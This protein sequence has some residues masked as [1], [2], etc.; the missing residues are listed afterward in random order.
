MKTHWDLRTH[1]I[2][3]PPKPNKDVVWLSPFRYP[4]VSRD[5]KH[6]IIPAMSLWDPNVLAVVDTLKGLKN[7]ERAYWH[8]RSAEKTLLHI[9]LDEHSNVLDDDARV[10]SWKKN[11]EHTMLELLVRFTN[12]TMSSVTG[13]HLATRRQEREHEYNVKQPVGLPPQ[14]EMTTASD[15]IW[16]DVSWEHLG[17]LGVC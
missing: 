3:S 16:P 13:D 2:M 10:E 14:H 8:I 12:D 5:G 7:Y 9:D 1:V 4:K 6:V 11:A 17:A 15:H